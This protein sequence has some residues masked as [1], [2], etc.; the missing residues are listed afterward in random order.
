MTIP[1]I[2]LGLIKG[3]EWLKALHAEMLAKLKKEK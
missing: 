1:P 2:S 3:A